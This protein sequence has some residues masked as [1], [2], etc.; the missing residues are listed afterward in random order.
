[1]TRRIAERF[2]TVLCV[3]LIC[4]PAEAQAHV[5]E[6]AVNLGDTSFLDAAGGPG[7]LV[8]DIGDGYH[9]RTPSVNSISSLTHLAW[10]SNHRILRAWYGVEVV[11]VAARV[12]VIDKGSA[13]GWGDLTV[14]PFI[15]QW[16]EQ[17]IGPIRIDQRLTFDLICPRGSTTEPQM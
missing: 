6:P 1:M 10:L 5:P 15:L 11:G 2:L 12:N 17:Q 7:L 4:A 14:S 8:E 9:S 16:N 3:S 13:E